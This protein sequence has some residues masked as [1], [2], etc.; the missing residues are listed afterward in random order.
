[1]P[2]NS[3]MLE[4]VEHL[5]R[6][7]FAHVAN[8]DQ[9]FYNEASL[10]HELAL[11]LRRELPENWRLHI[12]RPASFFRKAAKSLTKK[13][14]DLAIADAAL[15]QVVAIELKC[16]RQGQYPE[17][18]FK[19]CQDLQFLEELV[20]KGFSGGLFAM[21]VQDPLFYEGGS[22]TGIYA[23]FRGGVPVCGTIQKS[24]GAP[25]HARAGR[26][27]ASIRGSYKPIW[28]PSEGNHRYWGQHVM[29]S[30]A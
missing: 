15:E 18:M 2:H 3:Q 30:A 20:A 19:A 9:T 17:Q 13:E 10:Q 1:M 23:Y 22:R 29:P 24:T 21:H 14:I 16:P 7:F 12:E 4:N 11:F 8:P 26:I 5:V 28:T 6:Q 25:K 27:S